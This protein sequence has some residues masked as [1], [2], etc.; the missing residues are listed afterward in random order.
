[1]KSKF[2]QRKITFRILQLTVINF[3]PKTPGTVNKLYKH[4]EKYLNDII[5]NEN[6]AYIS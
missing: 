5:N 3:K 2:K 6:N 4:Y 1:M